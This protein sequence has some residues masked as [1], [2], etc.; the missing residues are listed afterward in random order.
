ME[1]APNSE[2]Y[3]EFNDP[4][5]ELERA[6]TERGQQWVD[7]LKTTFV[8]ELNELVKAEKE[9]RQVLYIHFYAPRAKLTL[10]LTFDSLAIFP[11]C[12]LGLQPSR[13]PRM[14]C[15]FV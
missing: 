10:N 2:E 4:K 15:K 9:V 1:E 5:S 12:V 7:N 3:D 6:I 11:N 8:T 13:C 14:P